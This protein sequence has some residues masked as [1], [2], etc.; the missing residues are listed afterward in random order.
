MMERGNGSIPDT[1]LPVQFYDRRTS[2]DT[3]EKRLIFAVLLDAIRQ[4]RG[5]D[6]GTAG[7]AARWIGEEI[8]DAPIS[9]GEACEALG[10]EADVLA[11]GLLTWGGHVG[12]AGLRARGFAH[13]QQRVTP[14]GRLRPF[15]VAKGVRARA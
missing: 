15:I 1:I 5:G 6:P 14:T 13:T 3:P 9:F 8:E 10:L 11:R 7:E 2:S 12:K 4:L